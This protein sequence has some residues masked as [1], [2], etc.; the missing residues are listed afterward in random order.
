MRHL[1]PC[2]SCSSGTLRQYS[3]K[4]KGHN[5]RRYLKCDRCNERGQEVFPIDELGRP[6]FATSFTRPGNNTREQQDSSPTM[7]SSEQ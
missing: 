3:T 7:K 2:P 1:D 4:T 5:R 6:L